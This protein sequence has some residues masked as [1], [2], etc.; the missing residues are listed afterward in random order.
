[1]FETDRLTLM[2]HMAAGLHLPPHLREICTILAAGL[3]RLRRHTAEEVAND[4]ACARD[5]GENSSHFVAQRSGHA[6]PRDRECA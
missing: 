6:N 1:M 2:D 4:P 3:V 5:Q